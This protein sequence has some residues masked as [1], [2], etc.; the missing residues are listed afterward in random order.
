MPRTIGTLRYSP[1]LRDGSTARRDGGSTRW[2][3]VIDCDPDLG[4]LLR[5]QF[6]L[7]VHRT[8]I[9]Q[10]PLW[11][12]H[13]SVIRGEEPPRK[14][15]WKRRDGEAVEL[16]YTLDV[17]ETEGY[18]WVP[19]LCPAAVECRRELGLPGEPSPPMHLTFGN[20]KHEG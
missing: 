2:W 20:F 17:R 9:P 5:H 6:A 15:V 11:G 12:T 10:P 16:E 3:L 13:V 18:L 7:G 14:E 4:R 1:E 19:V 8:R